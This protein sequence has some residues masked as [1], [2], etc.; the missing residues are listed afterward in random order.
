[1]ARS[2]DNVDY[3]LLKDDQ[4]DA[5]A[6]S[7]SDLLLGSFDPSK[8]HPLA[9]IEDKLDYLQLDDDK[10]TDLPGAGGAIPSRGWSDDLCYG[11]GTTYLSGSYSLSAFHDPPPLPS[12][13]FFEL[14]GQNDHASLT[15]RNPNSSHL[16][17]SYC[18]LPSHAHPRPP[19]L[20]LGGVWGLREG[21][22][23]PLAVSNARLRINSILNSITRRGTFMG[24][25]AGCLGAD[26]SQL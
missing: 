11:T 14:S 20:A 4:I 22:R 6:S 12:P 24:N 26:A 7:G 23:K 3:S 9:D 13:F 15:E 10:T 18:F 1:M 5:M 25:S 21:A 2:R 8:L 19:G 16:I 17:S